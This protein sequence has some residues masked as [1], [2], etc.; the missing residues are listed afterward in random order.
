[1]TTFHFDGLD[2]D[3][4]G[5]DGDHNDAIHVSVTNGDNAQEGSQFFPLLPSP[6]DW[7][8]LLQKARAMFLSQR[9]HIR[10]M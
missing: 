9:E 3:C 10:K 1:M 5:G 6:K 2:A 8:S 7:R 4:D